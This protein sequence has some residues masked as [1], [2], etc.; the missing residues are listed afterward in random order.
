MKS[1]LQIEDRG[2]AFS[3]DC[4]NSLEKLGQIN[5]GGMSSK[6][7]GRL[8]VK[9]HKHKPK[10]S[11]VLSSSSSSRIPCLD[12]IK[13][14]EDVFADDTLPAIERNQ[15]KIN[16][17]SLQQEYREIAKSAVDS[18]KINI[19][20]HNG[21]KMHK[22]GE[23]VAL[24]P[25]PKAAIQNEQ[26]QSKAAKTPTPQKKVKSGRL[27]CSLLEMTSEIENKKKGK[28]LPESPVKAGCGLTSPASPFSVLTPSKPEKHS[29][30]PETPTERNKTGDKEEVLEPTT[31]RLKLKEEEISEYDYIIPTKSDVPDPISQATQEIK[32]KD[33]ESKNKITYSLRSSS[34]CDSFC[35]F[36]NEPK[37]LK[38][39]TTGFADGMGTE[40][41]PLYLDESSQN[42]SVSTPEQEKSGATKRILATDQT[43]DASTVPA[44][45]DL[46]KKQKQTE[47]TDVLKYPENSQRCITLTKT[48]LEFLRPNTYIND[49]IVEFY[50]LYLGNEVVPAMER[51][52]Y[53]FFSPFFFSKLEHL[54]VSEIG[55]LWRWTKDLCI[56]KRKFLVIPIHLPEHWCIAIVCLQKG[57]FKEVEDKQCI[58]YFD[59][60]GPLAERST[61]RK[62]R[63]WVEYEILKAEG[64]KEDFKIND[65]KYFTREG[66]PFFSLDLPLQQNY[67][68]CGLF[69]LHYAELF[70][71]K[72]PEKIADFKT[73]FDPGDTKTKRRDILT[74]IASLRKSKF[75]ENKTEGK[76]E[77]TKE[78]NE[79][80]RIKASQA[81]EDDDED[82]ESDDEIDSDEDED[83]EDSI[84]EDDDEE[85]KDNRDS[86]KE[87]DEKE[88][89][90]VLKR[91]LDFN[92]VVS[93]SSSTLTSQSQDILASET[94]SENI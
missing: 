45:K 13:N 43:G 10:Y 37:R 18:P 11:S 86:D 39:K 32:P 26:H 7:A 33:E 51:D 84:E 15:Q 3:D 83:E 54:N 63:R 6:K 76:K 81:G 38:K 44:E 27:I 1:K 69:I 60:L 48:D 71:T 57:V 50:L 34:S 55:G 92:E 74:L 52:D 53:Y 72:R 41:N 21:T 56:Q 28:P 85:K 94:S 24:L 17:K 9:Q 29:N 89:D 67:T 65:P 23:K 40:S 61:E 73:W 59:S 19:G 46:P 80:D 87:E 25:S 70:I 8:P 82:D 20:T 42:I 49:S 88:D 79:I 78:E 5:S 14:L 62:L 91:P 31:K 35:M 36:E 16:Q 47:L 2:S 30:S 90:D 22:I 4:T 58:L 75:L 64:K 93:S 68:D 66:A 12:D 77:E